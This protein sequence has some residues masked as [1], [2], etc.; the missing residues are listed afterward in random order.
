M[1]I[2]H[3]GLSQHKGG[4]E[5]FAINSFIALKGNGVIF[6][7]ADIYGDGIAD[8]EVIR[9]IGGKIVTFPNFK[10][11]PLRLYINLSKYIKAN[12]YDAVHIHIQTAA[13]LLPILAARRAGV[14]PI[15]H[16]HTSSASGLLRGMLHALNVPLVRMIR[17]NRFSCGEVAGKWF[18]GKRDFSVIPNSVDLDKFAFNPKWREEKR[19][20]L[21]VSDDT[22]LLGF[23]G[24]LEQVKN[25]GF[26]LRILIDSNVK[27]P[28]RKVKLVIIGNGSLYEELNE[29]IQNSKKSD[30]AI[31][32]GHRSDIGKYLSAIDVFLMPSLHEA[33]SVAAVEAQSAG[34][35]CLFSDTVPKETAIS[36]GNAFLPI[37]S[38]DAW[39]DC[40]EKFVVRSEG[41][42]I[43]SKTAIE[44][45]VYNAEI[46]SKLLIDV[47]SSARS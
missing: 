7:F 31:M 18:W 17:A 39:V 3:V 1:K 5:S 37:T 47:Y 23:V 38:T 40:I 10:K 14:V 12:S 42:R 46:A 36:D 2:L 21:G 8:S 19:R 27:N 25:P 32:L 44:K 30:G 20:E 35:Y 15:V 34:C 29:E 16:N 6:D 43:L 11:H 28:D 22:L 24:R 9:E 4:I 41:E 33:F 13:N 26:A 45:S